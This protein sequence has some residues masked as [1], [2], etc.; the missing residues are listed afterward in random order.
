MSWFKNL[1]K[2][3]TPQLRHLFRWNNHPRRPYIRATVQNK[4]Q[5]QGEFK[6]SFTA[7]AFLAKLWWDLYPQISS[8]VSKP[9]WSLPTKIVAFVIVHTFSQR[10]IQ[11][12]TVQL[13]KVYWW[14]AAAMDKAM[15]P[16]CYDQRKEFDNEL[17]QH[18]FS[19]R[20]EGAK[21]EDRKKIAGVFL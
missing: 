18:C 5:L 17:F 3:G 11:S 2:G 13:L 15:S 14:D 21:T 9:T 4:G 19:C 20:K 6:E 8:Q 16:Y 7:D 12:K 1:Q 10:L